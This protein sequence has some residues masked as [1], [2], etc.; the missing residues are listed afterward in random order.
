MNI[1]TG[2]ILLVCLM[3]AYG[4]GALAQ[5]APESL[6][7]LPHS[8]ELQSPLQPPSASRARTIDPNNIMEMYQK[9]LREQEEMVKRQKKL[10]DEAQQLTDRRNKLMDQEDKDNKRYEGIMDKWEAQQ[11]QHQK[12]LDT[13]SKPQAEK[14]P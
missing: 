6:P 12:Y 4:G 3:A 9:G 5:Q 8:P 1:Q 7:P 11:A 10:L 13:L 2:R 14:A